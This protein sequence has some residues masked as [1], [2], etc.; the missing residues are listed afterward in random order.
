MEK[1]QILRLTLDEFH[2]LTK[3]YLIT[4]T[5]LFTLVFLTLKNPQSSDESEFIA[6][7]D[8]L[9][10]FREI[11][12]KLHRDEMIAMAERFRTEEIE[13]SNQCKEIT[14]AE[15]IDGW[16]QNEE[17]FCRKSPFLRTN[18]R[19]YVIN[20]FILGLMLLDF[21]EEDLHR[22]QEHSRLLKVF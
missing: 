8:R 5:T 1:Q 2:R 3:N 15:V 21:P 13:Y 10:T 18:I 16:W 20:P 14:I 6:C 4:Q 19:L 11:F 17:K 9:R 12:G 7:I 22:L